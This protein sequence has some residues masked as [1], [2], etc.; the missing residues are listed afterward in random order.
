MVYIPN[1]TFWEGDGRERKVWR[2]EEREE[3]EG[4]RGKEDGRK[5]RGEE[6]KR[7]RRAKRNGKGRKGVGR[8][9]KGRQGKGKGSGGKGGKRKGR[10]GSG[11]DGMVEREGRIHLMGEMLPK[12][13]DF[14]EIL[15]WLL[16]S[17]SDDQAKFRVQYYTRSNLYFSS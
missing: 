17:R 8:K 3:R 2:K 4:G 9:R 13:S 6:G 5:K 10:D 7:R 14:E 11:G 16:Y 12:N 15:N 1:F